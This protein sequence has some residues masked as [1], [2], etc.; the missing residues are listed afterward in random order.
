M[1]RWYFKPDCTLNCLKQLR[2]IW[3]SHSDS[4]KNAILFVL[5]NFASIQHSCND[6]SSL[7]FSFGDFSHHFNSLFNWHPAEMCVL[8]ASNCQSVYP[9]HFQST[10]YSWHATCNSDLVWSLTNLIRTA[11]TFSFS[12]KSCDL[13]CFCDFWMTCLT[14]C[15]LIHFWFLVFCT[16]SEFCLVARAHRIFLNS[17][18][19]R[20]CWDAEANLCWR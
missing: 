20:W 14:L 12:M 11:L 3:L 7:I 19:L 4:P 13:T 6:V 8:V 1:Q 10:V 15:W 5:V 17:A 16:F 9:K 2:L 18:H